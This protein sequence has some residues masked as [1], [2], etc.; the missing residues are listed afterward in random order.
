L[1][2]DCV[3]IRDD[4]SAFEELNFVTRMHL[5]DARIGYY[6]PH[7]S[8]QPLSADN[9][10]VSLRFGSMMESVF[11]DT[12]FEVEYAPCVDEDNRMNYCQVLVRRHCANSFT[13][14]TT[15]RFDSVREFKSVPK[16]P[17]N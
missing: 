16:N 4:V 10:T 6:S 14:K 5:P 9:R 17:Y 11:S 3:E 8:Y 12:P 2:D 7:S 1:S 15:F 13:E